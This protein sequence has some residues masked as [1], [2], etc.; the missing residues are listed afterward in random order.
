M[1]KYYRLQEETVDFFKNIFM[2]KSFPINLEF[3]FIGNS[4]QKGL[5][6]IAKIADQFE[7]I[8][9]KSLLVSINEELFEAFDDECKKILFEQEIDKLTIDVE[10]GKI[11]MVKT[12]LNTFSGLVKKWGI[13]KVSRANSVDTL[14]S[15]QKADME[16]E[17]I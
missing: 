7:F 13:E 1:D 12:D 2:Q 17:F 10:K 9:E 14:A 6:K 5:I 8:L 3:E 16:N 15:E 11:K 4:K